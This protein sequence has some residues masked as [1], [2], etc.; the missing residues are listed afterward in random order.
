VK[1][2]KHILILVILLALLA[3]VVYRIVRRPVVTGD[4]QEVPGLPVDVRQSVHVAK[5]K[6]AEV[7]NRMM[8][9]QE[10]K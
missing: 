8:H 5:K 10:Q 7:S 1:L 6:L 3:Y 9:P 4:P 2:V